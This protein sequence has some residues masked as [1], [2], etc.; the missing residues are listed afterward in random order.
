MHCLTHDGRKINDIVI[1][2]IFLEMFEYLLKI[3]LVSKVNQK[4]EH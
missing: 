1:H 4:E 3:I 2:N